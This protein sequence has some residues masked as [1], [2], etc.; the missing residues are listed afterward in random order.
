MCIFCRQA[1]F[2]Y[3]PKDLR[4]TNVTKVLLSLLPALA[5]L[6]TGTQIAQAKRF[7]KNGHEIEILWK[8]KGKKQLR[9]W[10]K[11]T[12]GKKTCKQ[13]NYTI[14]FKN[15]ENGYSAYVNGFINNYRPTGRNNYKASDDIS[16]TS[17]KKSWYVTSY[18]IKCL[19]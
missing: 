8:Q 4:K 1:P 14:R 12:E 15:S 10:G 7:H 19:N 18:E 3:H 5:I 9:V 17:H 16:P 13:M 6:F 2:A 11:I